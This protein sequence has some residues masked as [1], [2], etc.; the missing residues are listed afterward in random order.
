MPIFDRAVAVASEL[1]G[2]PPAR[3]RILVIGD[4]LGTDIAGAAAAGFD[5][6]FVASGIHAQE[7]GAPQPPTPRALEQ[8][9]DEI[10]FAPSAVTWRLSW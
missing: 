9:F 3:K 2:R 7:L 4:S 5:S 6:L 1:R 8:L 10:G